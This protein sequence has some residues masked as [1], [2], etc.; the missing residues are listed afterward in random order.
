MCKEKECVTAKP[1]LHF[2]FCH[3]LPERSFFWK[4][5]QFFMCARCTGI[6]LGYLSLPLFLFGV[7]QIPLLWTL[8]LIVPTYIDGGIQAYFNIESTN[9]RRF[10]T[11]LASGIATMSLT[12]IIGVAI[13]KQILL[14]IN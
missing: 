5:K 2:A 7:V 11:G 6:N 14:L 4:G 9:S 13:G 8:I 1:K 12:S 3:Q 10:I